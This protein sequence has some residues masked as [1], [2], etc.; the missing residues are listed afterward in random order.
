MDGPTFTKKN[1][2][3]RLAAYQDTLGVWTIGYGHTGP[4]IYDGLIWT[5]AECDAVFNDDYSEAIGSAQDDV[6]NICWASLN[7]ARQAAITDMA[8]QLGRNG[9][10]KFRHMIGYLQ[11]NDY[12]A[13]SAAALASEWANQTP[14]RAKRVSALIQSGEFPADA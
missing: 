7:E 1:E 12:E 13:A 3:C 6:G 5:Q 11:Q 10:A 8:F 14:V 9:L 2:G 4:D